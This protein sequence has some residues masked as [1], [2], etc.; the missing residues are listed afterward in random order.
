MAEVAPTTLDDVP[1]GEATTSQIRHYL[2]CRVAREAAGWDYA[3]EER[4]LAE[5]ARACAIA[6][7]MVVEDKL[8]AEVV[9]QVLTDEYPLAAEAIEATVSEAA[10]EV[11]R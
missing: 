7:A 5:Q 8:P 4:R 11:A 6:R 1:L 3:A 9:A 10:A 2:A